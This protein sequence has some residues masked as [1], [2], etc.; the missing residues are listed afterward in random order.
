LTKHHDNAR[1]FLAFC[2]VTRL[3]VI[4]LLQSGEKSATELQKQI[5]TGQSTLS[6]HMKILVESEIVTTRKAGKWTY[7]SICEN[8]SHYAIRLLRLLTAAKKSSANILERG[9]DTMKPFTIVVDTSCELSPEFIEEHGIEVMPIPFMLDD[10]EHKMGSWQEI[11]AKEF[12][13]ALR[14]GSKARTSQINPEAFVKAFTEYAKQ[15]KDVLFIILSS[16]LSATHQSSLI[17]LEEV[18]ESMPD[19]NIYPVDGLSATSLNTLLTI[20]AVKKREEGLT[21]GETATW[22]EEKKHNILG[23]FTVDDLMYLHR[24]GRLSKLSAIGGS[25]LGIKP[26]LNIQP[27]GTLALKDKVRGR[28]AAFKLMV[29]QLKRSINPDTVLDTVVITHTDCEGDALKL[30]EMVKADVKVNN[31]EVIM[32]GPVIGA[33]LGPGAVTL[34]LDAEITR[35]EYENKFYGGK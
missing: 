34:V 35:L 28:E 6:H 4:E 11:S 20:L 10:V 2:D 31:I 5:G 29:S 26:V 30:A 32:M 25:I 3:K 19:C 18:R 24:G 9:T 12:Y 16:G 22:L 1:V 7:Y 8:G 21:A 13:D 33:H 14:S 27:D 23:F 17:A 15:D